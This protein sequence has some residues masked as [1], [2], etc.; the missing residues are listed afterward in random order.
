MTM[1]PALAS[2]GN[3]VAAPA[4]AAEIDGLQETHGEAERALDC[5]ELLR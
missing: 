1:R 5:G 2:G 3:T 4:L